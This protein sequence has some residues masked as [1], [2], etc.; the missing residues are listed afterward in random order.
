[1]L[2]TQAKGPKVQVQVQTCLDGDN[3]IRAKIGLVAVNSYIL[4]Q[5]KHKRKVIPLRYVSIMMY[6]GLA[7]GGEFN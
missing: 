4:I 5:D 2:G 6:R 1:M 3:R 7:P